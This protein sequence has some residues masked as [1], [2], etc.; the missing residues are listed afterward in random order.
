[1]VPSTPTNS[2]GGSHLVSGSVNRPS[3]Q[4]IETHRRGWLGGHAGFRGLCCNVDQSSIA[5]K[6]SALTT[7]RFARCLSKDTTLGSLIYFLVYMITCIERSLVAAELQKIDHLFPHFTPTHSCLI[8][9]SQ[10]RATTLVQRRSN[11]K[12]WQVAWL[13]RAVTRIDLT[14]LP[15][16]DTSGN[17]Q[18]LAAK[19]RQP[20]RQ[21]IRH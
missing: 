3:Y 15:G 2:P 13:L 21:D 4:S 14:T 18:R 8:R 11:K 17:V 1:M 5:A 9:L 7:S 19:A 12:A 16:D 6:E 20:V 10:F